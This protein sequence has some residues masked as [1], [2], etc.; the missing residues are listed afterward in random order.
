[1]WCIS[2]KPVST[3]GKNDNIEIIDVEYQEMRPGQ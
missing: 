3:I 2:P 1:M